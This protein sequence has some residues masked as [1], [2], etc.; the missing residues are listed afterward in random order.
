MISDARSLYTT[1]RIYRR[2][3]TGR[4]FEPEAAYMKF[5]CKR[6][7]ICLHLG[8]SDGRH[9]FLLSQIV[10]PNGIVHAYE[11][12]AYSY[13]VMRRLLKWH[14]ISNVF[15]HNYAIGAADGVTVL[16]VPRKKSGHL[17]R[18]YAVV[19]DAARGSEEILATADE[20]EFD[21]Q[22]TQVTSLDSIVSTL[23]LDHVDF[24]R[25]DIE[26]AECLMIEGGDRTIK[27]T[28]PSFLI[29]IHPFSLRH[30]FSREPESVLQYFLDLGYEAWRLNDDDSDLIKVVELDAKRR[31]R[32]YFLVHP[33][34]AAE[35]PAGPFADQLNELRP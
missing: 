21:R 1:W 20:T 22:T 33:S 28:L 27:T 7:D 16:N 31:W 32:D 24:V 15:P 23:G 26:G 34:R 10:G 11:P 17:G 30:N 3:Q 5:I 12:S 25:C 4:K 9:S 18:A 6:G 8:A 19:G 2:N 29:E 35:L 13:K 14:K